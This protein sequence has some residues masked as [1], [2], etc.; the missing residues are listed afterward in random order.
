MFLQN[1]RTTCNFRKL[2][3]INVFTTVAVVGMSKSAPAAL[4]ET[5]SVV[6]VAAAAVDAVAVDV[7]LVLVVVVVAAPTMAALPAA[8][9]L[10]KHESRPSLPEASPFVPSPETLSVSDAPFWER[11]RAYW[12]PSHSQS[13]HRVG[14]PPRTPTALTLSRT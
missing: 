6:V 8:P 13:Q 10:P 9:D 5:T 7:L 14:S 1:M 3:L 11:H 12:C 2:S 4:V